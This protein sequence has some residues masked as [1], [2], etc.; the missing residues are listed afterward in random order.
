LMDESLRNAA[1]DLVGFVACGFLYKRDLDAEQSRLKRATKGATVAKLSVR[2]SKKLMVGEEY[3]NNDDESTFTTTLAS[4]RQGRGIEKRVLIA[5]AGSERIAQVLKE[6]KELEDDMYFNDLVVVPIVMPRGVAPEH[7]VLPACVA[8]PVSA[9][10]NWKQYIEDEAAEAI[11]QGVDIEKEGI[12]IILKKNGRV[13][14]RTKGIFLG[15]LLG[16]VVARREA[17]MDTTN[18]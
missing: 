14:Q 17:G 1:I 12:C 8:T 9:G 10:N 15:N 2:A 16:N 13:G 11:K 6:A 7:D 3:E 5:A 4:L 18:I